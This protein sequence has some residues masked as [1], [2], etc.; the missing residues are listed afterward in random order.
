MTAPEI[1]AVLAFLAF[2]LLIREFWLWY[3]RINQAIRLLESIDAS[4]KCLPAVSNARQLAAQS[5][6]KRA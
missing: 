4:L 6:R 1:G 5:L 3:F 2:F